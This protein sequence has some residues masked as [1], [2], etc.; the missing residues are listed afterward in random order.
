[1]D[2]EKLIAR[3]AELLKLVGAIDEVLRS[4]GWQVL[5]EMVFEELVDRLDRQLL[6]E[7]KKPVLEIEKIY[8]LQGEIA[9]AKRYDLIA[10]A[11]KCR[12]ELEGIKLN[13][14]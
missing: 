5:R 12:K 14:Q 8:I 1:M 2:R 3:R 7:A 4:K 9:N 10:Y 13:L 6:A 11:D